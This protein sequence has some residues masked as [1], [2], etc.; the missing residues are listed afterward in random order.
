MNR[1]LSFCRPETISQEFLNISPFPIKALKMLVWHL[2]R[3][4]MEEMSS[5]K[6]K[7]EKKPKQTA[8]YDEQVRTN[9][10]RDLQSQ[11][12]ELI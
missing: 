10:A 7:N 12:N 6:N 4:P 5:L 11:R 9:K 8:I 2:S 1:L 3:E